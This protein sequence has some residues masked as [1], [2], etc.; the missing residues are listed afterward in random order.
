ML[1]LLSSQLSKDE[2]NPYVCN[3][4]DAKKIRL[5][6]EIKLVEYRNENLP[7]FGGVQRVQTP[8]SEFWADLYGL[9][10]PEEYAHEL[11]MYTIMM[12]EPK[13]WACALRKFILVQVFRFTFFI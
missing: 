5:T 9:P 8:S 12:G 13:G 10:E 1:S 6:Y 3:R 11:S 2:L 7:V 4:M